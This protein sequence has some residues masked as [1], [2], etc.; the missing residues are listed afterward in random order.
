VA[1]SESLIC[2]GQTANL[3]ASGAQTYTWNPGSTTGNSITVAPTSNTTYTVTG[4]DANGCTSIAY[5]PIYVQVCN[6]INTLSSTNSQ[7]TVYPNPATDLINI[8]LTTSK[9]IKVTIEILDVRGS[10]VHKQACVFS[11]DRSGEQIAIAN[12]EPGIYLIKMRSDEEF[13]TIKLIKQ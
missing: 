9:K 11:N 1:A 7:I 4:T 6:G 10:L 5:Y 3:T 13:K 2:F 12:L 8:V